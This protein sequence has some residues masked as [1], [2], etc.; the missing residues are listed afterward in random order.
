M[1]SNLE[2]VD[3]VVVVAA[4]FVVVVVSTTVVV[5]AAAFVVERYRDD[6][7]FHGVCQAAAILM[8]LL[9]LVIVYTVALMSVD[10]AVHLK[11]PLTYDDIITP[12]RML[13]AI[14]IL[15]IFCIAISLLGFGIVGYSRPQ[16]GMSHTGTVQPT[17]RDTFQEY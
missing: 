5:V 14:A 13:V 11:K 15:W 7:G 16:D 9:L 12:W 6:T 4:A 3:I 2:D 17:L 1:C 10:R 8:I